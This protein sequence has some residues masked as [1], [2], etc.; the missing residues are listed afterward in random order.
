MKQNKSIITLLLIFLGL[1]I[2]GC[3][4]GPDVLDEETKFMLDVL[5]THTGQMKDYYT[6]EELKQIKDFNINEYK[7]DQTELTSDMKIEILEKVYNEKVSGKYKEKIT[8]L[9]DKMVIVMY[10]GVELE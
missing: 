9:E 3:S 2:S 4:S 10:A 8:K 5:Y 6:D 7:F 1:L